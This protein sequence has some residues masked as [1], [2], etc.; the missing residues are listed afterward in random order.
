MASA[1]TASF[2]LHGD[3]LDTPLA[4]GGA[5]MAKPRFCPEHFQLPVI[6]VQ[7]VALDMPFDFF[8]ERRRDMMSHSADDKTYH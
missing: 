5:D 1:N 8:F 4:I 6:A 2:R 3:S 7:R